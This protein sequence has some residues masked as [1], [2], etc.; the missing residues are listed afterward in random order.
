M[1]ATQ[2]LSEF[3]DHGLIH[4]EPNEEGTYEMD[5]RNIDIWEDTTCLG[6]L[7]E[8]MLLDTMDHEESKRARK[9]VTNYCWK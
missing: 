5:T 1:L 8:D 3:G 2:D 4:I 9:R 6:L 7:K